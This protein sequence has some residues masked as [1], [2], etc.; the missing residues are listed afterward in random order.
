[1]LGSLTQT[2]KSL[3]FPETD[4]QTTSEAVPPGRSGLD[5]CFPKPWCGCG[6]SAEEGS[7]EKEGEEKEPLRTQSL[8][9]HCL[10]LFIC[11]SRAY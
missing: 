4:R 2:Q 10:G 8:S 11:L 5:F 7:R 6:L 1:M 9:F 3:C